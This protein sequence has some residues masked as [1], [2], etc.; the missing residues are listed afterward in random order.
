MVDRT[1]SSREVNR[2][3]VANFLVELAEEFERNEGTVNVPVGNK[4]VALSPPPEV[5]LEV[6][7]VERS[8]VLRGSREQLE[9][10]IHWKP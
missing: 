4:T 3:E 2:S 6:E 8:P 7:V 5:S 9:I 10:D 1:Q